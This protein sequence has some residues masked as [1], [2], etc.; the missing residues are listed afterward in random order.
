MTRGPGDLGRGGERSRGP[1]VPGAGRATQA[2]LVN[3]SA[4]NG[5]ANNI[6]SLGSGN[7]VLW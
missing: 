5:S 2:G 4:L 6:A 7:I 3:V 1:S